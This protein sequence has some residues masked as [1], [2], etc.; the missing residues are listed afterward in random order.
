M[1]L[2]DKNS[3]LKKSFD[4]FSKV[5]SAYEDIPSAE[6]AQMINSGRAVLLCNPNHKN[7]KPVIIGQ[8]A[9]IK[10]NANIGTS[11]HVCSVAEEYKKLEIAESAGADTVMDLSTAGDLH[12]IR[13]EMLAR[14]SLPLGTVPLYA[15]AEKYISKGKLPED[16]DMDEIFDEVERQAEDG[17]DFMTIHTGLSLRGVRSAYKERTLGIVSRGGSIMARWMMKHNKENPLMTDFD[18]LLK[19]ALKHNVTLS[20]GDGL[21]PG[22]LCDAG[23]FAQWNEAAMLGEEVLKARQAGV[24]CMVEGPGHV[25]LNEVA[26]QMI[27]MKKLVHGAPL[28]ILGPLVVDTAVGYDHIAGAIGGAIACAAGADYL[29]YLTPAEHLTLPNGK[30]VKDGVIASR[31]AAHAADVALGRS[32]AVKAQNGM[33]VARKKLDWQAMKNFA[34]DPQSITDRKDDKD[35]SECA[36]CGEFCSVKL[37]G[38]D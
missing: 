35:K 18:R 20:L 13:K 17:V 3:F 29:C 23:D 36:M 16:M 21:R 26:S 4:K 30:D 7:V 5:L 2:F 9:R 27:T 31:I 25:G 11:G 8:P 38:K 24:C 32:Y 22:A 12:K 6:L 1:T 15:V 19:I 14:S 33:A 34:L 37:A 28:Y 10:V